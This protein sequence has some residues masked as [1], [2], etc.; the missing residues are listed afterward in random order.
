MIPAV[1]VLWVQLFVALIPTWRDGAYYSYGW[2]VPWLAAGLAWRRWK[3]LKPAPLDAPGFT[4]PQVRPVWAMAICLLGILVVPLRVIVSAD[5]GWRPPLL[6]HVGIVVFLTHF[7]M[8]RA[9]GRGASAGFVPVTLLALSAVPWPW[10]IEQDLV[11]ALTGRV[12]AITRECFLLFGKPVELVGER[13]VMSGNVVEVTDGCSGIRSLQSLIMVALFYGE[14]FLL[15]VPRRF[16]LLAVAGM[17]A[18]VFNTLRAYWLADLHFSRGAESAASAHDTLG[19]LAFVLSALMLWFSAR[20]L[21]GSSA[22]HASLVRR[23]VV[24]PS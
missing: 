20:L 14:L 22:R 19:H 13:L 18:L 10:R 4:E 2:F 8:A 21:L 24:S 1:L 23:T 12:L 5:P 17:V 11:H 7:L 6:L 3:M 15:T 16:A 9:W